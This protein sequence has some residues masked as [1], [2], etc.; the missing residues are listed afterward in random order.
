M[1]GEKL[2]VTTVSSIRYKLA[3]VY[4]EDSNQS[5]HMHSL[6]RVLVFQLK[7]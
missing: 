2:N 3:C 4:I 7:E 6:I 1:T 5:G